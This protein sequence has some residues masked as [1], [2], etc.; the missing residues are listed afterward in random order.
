MDY[1]LKRVA[2]Y[3]RSAETEELLDRV[4]VY[5]EGMEPAALDLMEGELD[6]RGVSV[7]QIAAH[8]AK[9]RTGAI[10]LSD[11]T[12][13]R[14]SFCDRPAVQQARGWHRLRLRVPFAAL[15]IGRGSA[16]LGFSVPL[17]PRVFAYCSFHWRP[18]KESP[19]DANLPHEPGS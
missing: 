10:M 1:D 6:R 8:D 16:P 14:C 3:I 15:F 17:F 4:T 11:G 19:A 12:A 9:Q 5:R 18:P 7:A 13:R 2:E